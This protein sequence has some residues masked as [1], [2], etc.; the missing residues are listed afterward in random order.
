MTG[1]KIST[2]APYIA[3]STAKIG[4]QYK[5]SGNNTV[6]NLGFHNYSIYHSIFIDSIKNGS[7]IFYYFL[8]SN[9]STTNFTTTICYKYF[10]STNCTFILNYTQKTM[11]AYVN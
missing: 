6:S 2:K 11:A 9:T 3:V 5:I 4:G 8:V 7:T 1:L 10:P